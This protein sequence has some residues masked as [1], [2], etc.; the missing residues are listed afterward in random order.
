[1]YIIYII[2]VQYNEVLYRVS[3][4]NEELILNFFNN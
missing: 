2:S 1:M 4:K 3:H